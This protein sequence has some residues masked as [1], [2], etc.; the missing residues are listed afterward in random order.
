L[1][2]S[3]SCLFIVLSTKNNHAYYDN[4]FT[5]SVERSMLSNYRIKSY[6]K[7]IRQHELNM[8]YAHYF[9]LAA[10]SAFKAASH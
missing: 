1:Y 3:F 2:R 6:P 7:S 8:Q 10:L 9:S 5:I 4:Y